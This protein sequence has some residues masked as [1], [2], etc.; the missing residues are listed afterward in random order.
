MNT[1]SAVGLYTVSEGGKS[2]GARAET[3]ERGLSC[4]WRGRLDTAHLF[5][6]TSPLSH[7]L[8]TLSAIGNGAVIDAVAHSNELERIANIRELST[9]AMASKDGQ[10]KRLHPGSN[11]F[12]CNRTSEGCKNSSRRFSKVA[13]AKTAKSRVRF[14]EKVAKHTEGKIENKS[15]DGHSHSLHLMTGDPYI[16]ALEA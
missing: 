2:E 13:H 14:G 3:Q 12:E 10:T 16:V 15:K 1:R 11:D 6:P 7:S 5:S 8:A 9:A 4:T